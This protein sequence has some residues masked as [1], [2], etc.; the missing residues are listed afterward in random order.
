MTGARIDRPLNDEER[1]LLL[2]LARRNIADTFPGPCTHDEAT[3]VLARLVAEGQLVIEGNAE[4]VFVRGAGSLLAEAKRD[5]LSFHS[6]FPGH[7]PMADA[8]RPG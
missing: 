6:S 7:N 8:R 3:N 5:W 1:S 4:R 2:A